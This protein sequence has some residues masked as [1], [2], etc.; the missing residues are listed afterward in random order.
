MRKSRFTDEQVVAILREAD[1]DPMPT[2]AKRHGISEQTIYTW[3]RRFGTFQTDD[4][5][6][7]KQLGGRERAAEEA[8]CR[9]RFGDRGDEGDR[10]KKM[11]SVPARRSAVAYATGKGLSPAPAG[12]HAARCRA[13]GVALSIAQGEA[14]TRP[15]K[16]S[17]AHAPGAGEAAIPA[18]TG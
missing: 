10:R 4:V 6:R 16:F 11:V 5:R 14:R 1:R 2:V 3:R 8:G 18:P 7:L 17:R 9:A 12:L 13:V 15:P